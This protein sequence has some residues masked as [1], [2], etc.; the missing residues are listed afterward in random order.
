MEVFVYLPEVGA[1]GSHLHHRME[2]HVDQRPG[3]RVAHVDF[4]HED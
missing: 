4:E 3:I 1:V 2:E